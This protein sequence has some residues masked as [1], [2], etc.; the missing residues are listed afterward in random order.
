[1]SSLGDQRNTQPASGL[2]PFLV[3]MVVVSLGLS[4]GINCGYAINPAR[5]LGPRI[6]TS[7]IYGSD[8]FT[9]IFISC[10]SN[11]SLW[12]GII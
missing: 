12:Y 11:L 2:T 4:F 1:M 8:V 5:D 10:I 9:G 6:F 7:F 3:G